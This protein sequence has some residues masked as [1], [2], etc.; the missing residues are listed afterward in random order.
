MDI[1][2]TYNVYEQ[3]DDGS[4]TLTQQLETGDSFDTNVSVVTRVEHNPP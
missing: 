3:N 2:I 4:W 1:P